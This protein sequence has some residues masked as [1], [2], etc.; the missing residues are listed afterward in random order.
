MSG[1]ELAMVISLA[2]VV[3]SILSVVLTI[4]GDTDAG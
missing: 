3:V 4:W 1:D 2:S